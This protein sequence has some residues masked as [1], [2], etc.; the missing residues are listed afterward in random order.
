MDHVCYG[1]ELTLICECSFEELCLSYNGGKD[2]LVLLV[3]Y[4]AAIHMHFH[5]AESASTIATNN[6][7]KT[8]LSPS[9]PSITHF[10]RSLKTVYIQSKDPFSEV[11]SFVQTSSQLYHLSLVASTL[12]MKAAFAQYLEQNN[13]VKAIFVG[14]RRT[15]PHGAN[16]THFDPTD[17]GWPPFMRIHPVIDWHYQE[18]WAV[19]CTD[20]CVPCMA[21]R[22][23]F[24]SSS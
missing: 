17:S 20:V 18:I 11:D 22:T 24:P 7:T 21:N 10:P 12:P 9:V 6:D 19:S 13:H 23:E 8:P 15:D 1:V 2:C 16:L 5:C 3:I 4:L 14:T